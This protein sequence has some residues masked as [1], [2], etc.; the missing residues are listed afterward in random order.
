MSQAIRGL[1]AEEDCCRGMMVRQA[2]S[3][4]ASRVCAHILTTQARTETQQVLSHIQP[5]TAQPQVLTGDSWRQTQNLI[6]TQ[7]HIQGHTAYDRPP[8]HKAVDVHAV[9]AWGRGTRDSPA[10]NSGLSLPASS[11]A[12]A[13]PPLQGGDVPSPFLSAPPP[14]LGLEF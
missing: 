2:L 7:A 4:A 9:G 12:P 3:E 6:P 11:G 1:G 10:R 5:H 8:S 13:H 14:T